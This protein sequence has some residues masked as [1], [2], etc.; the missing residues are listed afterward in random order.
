MGAGG[1]RVI[2]PPRMD[3]LLEETSVIV[4]DKR[5]VSLVR[6]FQDALLSTQGIVEVEQYCDALFG[7]LDLLN[8]ASASF[9]RVR[10]RLEPALS[11]RRPPRTDTAIFRRLADQADA[12]PIVTGVL[13]GSANRRS[14]PSPSPGI[15]AGPS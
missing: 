2:L 11:L 9:F 5:Y 7:E 6:T 12:R 13:P 3:P 4:K 10:R 15:P 1:D 8:G 14:S